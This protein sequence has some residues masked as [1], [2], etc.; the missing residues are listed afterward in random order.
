M[1]DSLCC[2]KLQSFIDGSVRY[3]EI[4]KFSPLLANCPRCLNR[5]QSTN[6][7][8]EAINRLKIIVELSS[9][10]EVPSLD[11]IIREH[12]AQTIVSQRKIESASDE[13]EISFTHIG[14]F[15]LEEK[16]GEGSFGVVYRAFD[17]GLNRQVAIKILKPDRLN[18]RESVELF[19]KEAQ[20]AAKLKHPGLIPIHDIGQTDDRFCFAVMEYVDAEPLSRD[21]CPNIETVVDVMLQVASALEHA[22]QQMLVHRDVK[23]ANIL[24]TKIGKAYLAD[25]G[26]VLWEEQRSRIMEVVGTPAFMSPEQI[27]GESHRLDGRTDIWA[28]GVTLYELLTGH[29]PFTAGNFDELVHCITQESPKPVRQHNPDVHPEL[30]R[31]CLRCLEKRMIDRFQSAADLIEDLSQYQEMLHRNELSIQTA[32][33]NLDSTR[34]VSSVDV[35]ITP[36]GLRAYGAE[37]SDFYL[38]ML[39]GPVDR[40]GFP[41]DVRFWTNWAASRECSIYHSI[42]MI[43]GPSGCGK[44]SL[45]GAGIVPNLTSDVKVVFVEASGGILSDEIL[46]RL[47]LIVPAIGEKTSLVE[48]IA[49]SRKTGNS[50]GR[51][52]ILLIIDQFEQWLHRHDR[53]DYE[54][55]VSALRQCDGKNVACLFAIRSDF[56]MSATEFFRELETLP[57]SRNSTPI[58]LVSP[59]HARKVLRFL[60]MAYGKFILETGLSKR[61][62]LF[63]DQAIVRITQNGKV[64]NIVLSLFAEIFKEANWDQSV[65]ATDARPESIG[66]SYLEQVIDS[67]AANPLVLSHPREIESILSALLPVE[68]VEIREHN[69]TVLKL[70]EVAGIDSEQRLSELINILDRE[71][72]LISPVDSIHLSA[73]EESP[74]RRYQLSH[75]FL[76]PSIR[77]WKARKHDESWRGIARLRLEE[78]AKDW[79]FRGESRLLPSLL[80]ICKISL[81]VPRSQRTPAQESMM[82]AARQKYS[83]R[84]GIGVVLLLLASLIGYRTHAS[85]QAR[86]AVDNLLI[87]SPE[88]VASVI[89]NRVLPYIGPSKKVAGFHCAW[90]KWRSAVA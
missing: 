39:P 50:F 79:A 65:F 86:T 77:K 19:L 72:R 5:L 9:P 14:R 34:N 81:A 53:S 17:P 52:K 61:E 46:E 31:I 87:A 67:S 69:V 10:P 8:S 2:T 56:F 64:S 33:P 62:A 1:Q 11:T 3:Q 58:R 28:F 78:L 54:Q 55:L 71:L 40:N 35:K 80:E 84:F 49:N 22:H 7:D 76:V 59:V 16:V 73:K 21:T 30:A 75:D 4:R 27:N 85:Y 24:V 18:S 60:G 36:K 51:K 20:A 44:S 12:Q 43:Y 89:D 57:D 90:P 74:A 32:M 70:Q 15:K 47:R 63:L 66:V 88:N 25:L 13:F 48:A 37:D 29:R 68:G 6:S 83:V 26:L 41:P 45:I 42:G 38:R 82:R 23:P